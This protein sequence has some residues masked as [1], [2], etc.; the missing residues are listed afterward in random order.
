VFVDAVCDQYQVSLTQPTN[1][2]E[3]SQL[4]SPSGFYHD[5]DLQVFTEAPIVVPM[6]II[7]SP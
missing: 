3:L 2:V 1:H 5:T 7:R 4:L 6:S